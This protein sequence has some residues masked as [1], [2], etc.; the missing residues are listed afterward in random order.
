MASS[1]AGPFLALEEGAGGAVSRAVTDLEGR[2][3]SD[4]GAFRG[5]LV[6]VGVPV[7][8]R[9]GERDRDRCRGRSRSLSGRVSVQKIISQMYCYLQAMP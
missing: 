8:F 7:P 9:I 5:D 1:A 6:L 2:S 4:R 3:R